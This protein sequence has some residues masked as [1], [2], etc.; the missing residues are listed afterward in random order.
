MIKHILISIVLC[1]SILF[2]QT[3]NAQEYKTFMVP[4]AAKLIYPSGE[5]FN[6]K[7]TMWLLDYSYGMGLRT[8]AELWIKNK[9]IYEEKIAN[10][11]ALIILLNNKLTNR[12]MFSD[13]LSMI[14]EYNVEYM[15]TL[16]QIFGTPEK[17]FNIDDWKLGIGIFLGALGTLAAGFVW[18][19]AQKVGR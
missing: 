7:S 9:P 18:G 17:R 4:S 15:K 8:D 5:V 2:S 10:R 19:S 11:D 6:V 14:N 12:I 3:T 13:N 1:I 16:N